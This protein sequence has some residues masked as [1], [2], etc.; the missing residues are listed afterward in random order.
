MIKSCVI[1]GGEFNARGSAKTCGPGHA[2]AIKAATK[3]RWVNENREKVRGYNIAWDHRNRD[4]KLARSIRY[5]K[6][7][8]A[9][10]P[11]KVRAERRRFYIKNARRLK[12]QSA[13]RQRQMREEKPEYVKCL[14]KQWL[15]LNKHSARERQR[16]Y[17]EKRRSECLERSEKFA[18]RYRAERA[19]ALQSLRA[20]GI[21]VASGRRALRVLREMQSSITKEKVNEKRK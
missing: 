9:L 17:Y 10:H 13:E 8:A 18:V 19:A 2:E 3:R 12:Q 16:R 15:T 14:K 1:C 6:K 11:K 4:A 7:R 21:P 20:I 5:S